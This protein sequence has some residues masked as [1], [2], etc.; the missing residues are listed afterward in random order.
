MGFELD[1]AMDE[2]NDILTDLAENNVGKKSVILRKVT[3]DVLTQTVKNTRVDTGAL[4]NNWQVSRNV[5][6]KS[7]NLTFNGKA[8][9]GSVAPQRMIIN[10][11]APDD[12]VYIQNNLEY[13]ETWEK[14][15]HMLKNAVN[16]VIGDLS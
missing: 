14:R 8:V 9:R 3:L 13:A 12:V 10:K 11:I 4:R 15:D 6:N 7:E 2:L 5:R 1:G 16:K